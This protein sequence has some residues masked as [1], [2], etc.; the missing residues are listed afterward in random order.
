[1]RFADSEEGEAPARMSGK[2]RRGGPALLPPDAVLARVT[3][4][5][6]AFDVRTGVRAALLEAN[7]RLLSAPEALR[8]APHAAGFVAILKPHEAALAELRRTA[9]G[10]DAYLAARGAAAAPA[11][12]ARAD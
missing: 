1:V 4:G 3:A 12:D 5:D 9:L 2:R 8:E 11:A 7:E 10:R 6:A